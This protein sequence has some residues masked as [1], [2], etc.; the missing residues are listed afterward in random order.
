MMLDRNDQT[1][2]PR[3]KSML[4]HLFSN[5]F[6]RLLMHICASLILLMSAWMSTNVAHA[7]DDQPP[8]PDTQNLDQRGQKIDERMSKLFQRELE[9]LDR[10][11]ER[12]ENPEQVVA[13]V[14]ELISKASEKGLDVTALQEALAAY[15]ASVAKAQSA[16]NEAA[17]I[18]S[19][20]E[21]FDDNGKVIERSNARQTLET[22]GHNLNEARR[23]LNQAAHKLR[24]DVR[25]WLR[26]QRPHEEN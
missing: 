23:I 14:E 2:Y 11:A 15:Q 22:A 24:L 16:H 9:W 4:P 12:L 10:Q 21:G 20:H 7:Q 1:I 8:V 5:R 26:A 6:T 19:A 18:L 17:S 13:R 3:R 25:A